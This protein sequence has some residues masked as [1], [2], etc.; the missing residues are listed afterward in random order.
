[1]KKTGTKR[2]L[3][4]VLTI[5]ML[6][7]LLPAHTFALGEYSL[8][9]TDPIPELGAGDEV[10]FGI[11]L[12]KGSAQ[13]SIGDIQGLLLENS[14]STVADVTLVHT[15]EGAGSEMDFAAYAAS[16]NKKKP[17]EA[18]VAE[19]GFA[20]NKDL[21]TASVYK[22][23][24]NYF[25][26]KDDSLYVLVSSVGA[27]LAIDIEVPESGYYALGVQGLGSNVGATCEVTVDDTLMGVYSFYKTGND[28]VPLPERQLGAVYLEKGSATVLLEKTAD[29]ASLNLTKLSL[30]PIGE[31]AD[32]RIL[33]KKVG[34]TA[35]TISGTVEGE[36]VEK[37]FDLRVKGEPGIRVNVENKELLDDPFEGKTLPLE[38]SFT[39]DGIPSTEADFL[40]MTSKIVDPL[41]VESSELRFEKGKIY[42]DVTLKSAGSTRAVVVVDHEE[43]GE[44]EFEIPINVSGRGYQY[45]ILKLHT[46]PGSNV[47]LDPDDVTDWSQTTVGSA[48]EIGRGKYSDP[49][50]Y[51]G[52]RPS[53]LLMWGWVEYGIAYKPTAVGPSAIFGIDVPATGSYG[54]SMDSLVISNG[55]MFQI[56]IAPLEEEDPYQEKY[57]VGAP[58]DSYSYDQINCYNIP[59]GTV[60]LEAGKYQYVLETVGKNDRSTGYIFGLGCIRLDSPKG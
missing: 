32:V 43:Y 28:I 51:I 48:N 33:A 2:L 24:D 53:E 36:L 31:T 10:S 7:A 56:Y 60:Y 39:V 1:M 55:G 26:W 38:L 58:I 34:R 11:G 27:V 25:G 9:E 19:D 13:E 46:G 21:T 37:T 5:C 20:I 30:I 41:L 15:G 42:L 18:T 57:K 16:S 54:V 49:W 40:S 4:L 45:N 29:K 52:P 6:L 22:R 50:I 35:V 8:Q 12:F 44:Q 47:G 23:P 14:D 3:S 17:K 59:V